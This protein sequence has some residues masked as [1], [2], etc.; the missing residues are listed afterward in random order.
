MSMWS[1]NED[2]N[3]TNLVIVTICIGLATYAVVAN[4]E[5]TVRALQRGVSLLFNTPRQRLVKKMMEERDTR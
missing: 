3:A 4:L 2:Y 1:I 5:T